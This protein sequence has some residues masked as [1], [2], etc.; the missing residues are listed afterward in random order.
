MQVKDIKEDVGGIHCKEIA[1]NT[2]G[3]KLEV[4]TF[5]PYSNIDRIQPDFYF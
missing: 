2:Y 3:E 1:H 5:I 4:D